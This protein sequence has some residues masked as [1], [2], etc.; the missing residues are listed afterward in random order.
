MVSFQAFCGWIISEKSTDEKGNSQIQTIRVQNNLIRYDD[1]AT[2]TVFDLNRQSVLIAFKGKNIYWSGSLTEFKEGITD[3]FRKQMQYLL[4]NAPED[5]RFYFEN[6]FQDYMEA[7]EEQPRKKPVNL[8]VQEE[9]NGEMI[10][11]FKT[12]KYDVYVNDTLK[13]TLWITGEINP[14][15]GINMEKL[16]DFNKQLS[17]FD[18]HNNYTSAPTYL[19]VIRKGMIVRSV[20]YYPGTGKITTEVEEIQKT[21]LKPEEF[22]PPKG[23]HKVDLAELLNRFTGMNE[24]Q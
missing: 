1:E 8:K 11:G 9:E 12:S 23:Y 21:D 17:P 18:E 2:R 16:L 13:E 22:G 5:Q 19:D 15:A 14:Y 3:A 24:D 7:I 6:L 4:D 20:I 10:K